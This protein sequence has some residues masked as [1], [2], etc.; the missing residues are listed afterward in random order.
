MTEA[1]RCGWVALMGPP[2]AGKSTLTNALVGARVAIVTAKPQTTRNRITGILTRPDA[3]VIFMDTPGIY[4]LRGHTRGQLGKLMTQSAWQS[5]A[6]A[7]VVMLVLDADLYLRKG[8]DLMEKEL[9][10]LLRPLEEEERPV[11]VAVN[12]VDMFH[13][14]SKMLP[15]LVRLAELLPKAEIFPLS[16]MRRNG[17]TQLADLI[18]RYLPEGEAKYPADQLSTAPVRFMAAEIIREKLFDRLYQEVPYA[19]AVDVE[20]WDED[21]SRDQIIIH[22]SIF[23]ARPSHKA[24]VIGKA[25]AGIKDIGTEARKRI[26]ELVGKKVHLELWVKVREDW[27]DD[28][29]FLHELGFGAQGD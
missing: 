4:S 21:E 2:N 8:L 28:A 17:T 19:V 24:M 18:V 12:K 27:V 3:Q 13:D 26:V 5:F 1:H 15:L 6:A 10:P 22:A 11:I 25:G 23:V 16:A 20:Q 7:N 9:A 29:Q 14:K